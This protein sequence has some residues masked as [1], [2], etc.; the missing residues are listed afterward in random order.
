MTDEHLPYRQGIH[1]ALGVLA[2]QWVTAVL[3]SL[4]L[5][6]M[7]YSRLL[8]DINRME[9]QLGWVVHDR[10]LSQKVLTDTLSRM[11][12]D[13]LVMKIDKPSAFG[14]TCYQLTSVGRALQ[15]ALRPL[16]KWAEDNRR[17]VREAQ[18]PYRADRND[19]PSA[20]IG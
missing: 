2:G 1:E 18:T 11:Q 14:K 17:E 19:S 4:N 5:H 9:A 15:R 20:S 8:E 16:A 6:P 10:P 7:P 3:A 12:R 13:G